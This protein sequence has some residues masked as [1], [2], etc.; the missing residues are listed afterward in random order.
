MS[1]DVNK[2]LCT[3]EIFEFIKEYMPMIP[4]LEIRK[5][6][7]IFSMHNEDV[8][9]VLD[10]VGRVENISYDGKRL[11]VNTVQKDDFTGAIS[12]VFDVDFQCVGVAETKMKVLEFQPTVFNEL[13]K[14]DKFMMFFYQKTN[15]R[16]HMMYK[17]ILARNIFSQ[18][19]LLAYY[20]LQ[21]NKQNIFCYKSLQDL[22]EKIGISKTGFYY[23]M[24]QFET[25]G[26]VK[27]RDSKYQI[28]YLEKLKEVAEQVEIFWE[29]AKE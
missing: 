10:G 2:D 29:N 27:K 24:N 25:K 28:I 16:I 3:L 9:Y 1:L 11:M 19:E 13:M 18:T 12:K 5:R 14:D 26:Y 6:D 22:C 23:I 15:K 20:I 17:K 8:Y 7:Y 21:N 4:V